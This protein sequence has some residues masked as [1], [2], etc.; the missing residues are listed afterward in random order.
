MAAKNFGGVGADSSAPAT[1][2]QCPEWTKYDSCVRDAAT[3]A[4]GAPV[5]ASLKNPPTSL[6]R[7]RRPLAPARTSGRTALWYLAKPMRTIGGAEPSE[8]PHGLNRGGGSPE[9]GSA[10][11]FV[12]C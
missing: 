9:I 10:D 11:R 1:P 6:P 8:N 3:L 5:A 7:G 2:P 12:A 4:L